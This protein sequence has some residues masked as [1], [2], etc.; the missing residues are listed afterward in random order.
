MA[1]GWRLNQL[2]YY[3]QS[4]LPQDPVPAGIANLLAALKGPPGIRLAETNDPSSRY[5]GTDLIP[6][7][8]TTESVHPKVNTQSDL[9]K[10]ILQAETY[11]PG[12]PM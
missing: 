11:G 8:Y 1:R 2:G 3:R 12:V 10:A 6:A 4:P 7:I 5:M 9:E